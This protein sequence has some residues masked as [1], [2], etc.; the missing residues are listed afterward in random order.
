MAKWL[1]E[2]TVHKFRGIKDLTLSG[3]GEVN[4]LVG[5]NNS[6]KTSVLEAISTFAR[7]FD[8]YEWVNTAWRREIKASRRSNVDAL[9]WLFPWNKDADY[10]FATSEI[11]IS[12][13]GRYTVTKV[14][15]VFNGIYRLSNSN[16]KYYAGTEP[17]EDMESGAEL[18][19]QLNSSSSSYPTEQIFEIWNTQNKPYPK[20]T[21][22]SLPVITINPITHRSEQ[23]GGISKLIKSKNK[24]MVI[25]LLK[26]FD[27][28][29]RD[30]VLINM[31]G[32]RST[33]EIDHENF[34]MTV[35]VSAF[36]DG[37]R[38]ALTFALSIPKAKGGFLLV[39]EIESAIHVSAL[40][41][42]YTWL[43]KICQI[44]EI[45][46]FVTTHS[47][48]AVEALI[49]AHKAP[50]EDLTAFQLNQSA[51]PV[52]RYSGELL[53]RLINERGLDVR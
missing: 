30:I 19:V 47:L 52:K 34:G 35:P 14:N 50:Y 9:K 4:I 26:V 44:N 2:I 41:E 13:R 21:Q 10:D 38:R 5:G 1:D 23:I 28:G 32:M 15:T 33:I 18:K 11:T 12:G 16:S 17:E 22:P 43:V 24:S 7:P 3:L 25:D 37:M 49:D 20:F 29:V 36:G 45:Q 40:Q 46:L 39:D 53:N 51:D 42:L 8:M 31:P 6:G 27:P 48:E